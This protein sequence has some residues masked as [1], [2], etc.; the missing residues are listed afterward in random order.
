MRKRCS[1]EEITRRYA[2]SATM[3]TDLTRYGDELSELPEVGLKPLEPGA[4]RSL[5]SYKLYQIAVF[6]TDM[7][8]AQHRL[9]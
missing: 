9:Y 5:V 8:F 7:E 3:M 2:N 1:W 6:N 4:S